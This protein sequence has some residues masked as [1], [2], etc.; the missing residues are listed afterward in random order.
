[1]TETRLLG[2]RYELGDVLGRGGMAEVRYGRDRR[3]GRAVA[4]KM[5]RVDH[6]TDPTFQERFRR[7]AQS[8]ASLNHRNIV[9]V[10]DTGEDY[11]DGHLIPYIVMEYVEGRTLRDLVREQA[12]FT[13]ERSIEV[14]SGIL[15][16][17]EYSHRAG[18]VHR[19]IKPG[20]VMINGVG[21]VKVMD[22]G[23]ARSLAETGAALTQTAAVVGTAQYISPEQARGESA[24]ARSDLYAL[25]CVLYEL[26]TG[27]PP[28]VGESLVSVAVSHVREMATPPSALDPSI[29]RDLDAIVLKALAKDRMERYQSAYDMRAD[30]ER[31]A[32]GLPVSA[33]A[34]ASTQL[35]GAGG[36]GETAMYD[37]APAGYD[38]SFDDYDEGGRKKGMSWGAL[39]LAALAILGVA[40]LIGYLAFRSTGEEGQLVSVPN[41]LGWEQQAAQD[42]A[43]DNGVGLDIEYREVS[44]EDEFG[45][46]LQQDPPGGDRVTEGGTVEIVV[47]QAPDMVEVPDLIGATVE[48]ADRELDQAGLSLGTTSTRETTDD[49]EV[50]RVLETSPAGGE[51]VAPGSAVDLVV[52][53][54]PESTVVPDL[55][56]VT[57]TRAGELLED[58]GLELGDVTEDASDEPVGNVISSNPR[59]GTSVDPGSSVDIVL[60]SGP[61]EVEVPNVVGSDEDSARNQLE[62]RG[63]S[64]EVNHQA[65]ACDAE[66]DLVY[67][68]DPEGGS[69]HV[70][71]ET[72]VQIWV[73]TN[74]DC[75]NGEGPRLPGN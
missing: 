71:S 19:D 7:E 18:I 53:A 41:M 52:G 1:M 70:P 49:D 40:A 48:D 11:V 43:D 20:N 72:T 57:E 73:A 42:W 14:T 30:L 59:G 74:E 66:A 16:A 9:A 34:T 58:A 27:R 51:S 64:V 24:D 67:A 26:L 3:L 56:G 31:C 68:Q 39:L 29:P 33:D 35:I 61:A 63:F 32:A 5:L 6:A 69:R 45:T 44:D 62:Q 13:P 46:V 38:E 2:E 8:A 17:L 22:F 12:R 10:Y 55:L 28:F 25:G 65:D 21:E 54:E 47:G 75:P 37:A 23:I 15:D 36:Y 60:S 50:G 4:I